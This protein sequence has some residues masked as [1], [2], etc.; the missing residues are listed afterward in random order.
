[1]LTGKTPLFAAGVVCSLLELM[2]LVGVEV[3]TSAEAAAHLVV[4]IL[5]FHRATRLTT[6]A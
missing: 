1:M 4:R 5:S 2:A 3:A 6:A